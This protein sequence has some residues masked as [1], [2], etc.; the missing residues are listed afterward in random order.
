MK[1]AYEEIDRLVETAIPLSKDC[2]Y[3]R[4]KQ[5][6][7]RQELKEGILLLLSMKC[8]KCLPSIPNCENENSGMGL[9]S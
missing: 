8:E 6:A 3:E 7:R 9:E 4:L 5:T 1:E 2:H